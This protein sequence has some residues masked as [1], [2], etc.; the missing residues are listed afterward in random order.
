MVAVLV[1][2]AQLQK[3]GCLKPAL[4]G[5]FCDP[6]PSNLTRL[7]LL[8]KEKSTV[9]VTKITSFVCIK[10][11]YCIFDYQSLQL[12]LQRLL[13]GFEQNYT[14]LLSV[15]LSQKLLTPL[16]LPLQLTLAL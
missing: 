13:P 1:L 6:D 3:A 8:I 15:S 7:Q 9:Y 2:V 5:F 16:T 12:K 11:G 10:L 4:I 14:L